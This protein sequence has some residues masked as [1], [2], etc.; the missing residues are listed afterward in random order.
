MLLSNSIAILKGVGE[1]TASLL[2]QRKIYT[3]GDL[4]YYLPRAYDDWQTNIKLKDVRAGN[5]VVKCKVRN[6][7]SERRKSLTIIKAELYDETNSIEAIWFNQSYRVKQLS[8]DKDF[9]FAGNFAFNYGRYQLSNP[10]VIVASDINNFSGDFLPVYKQCGDLK[11]KHFS[12]IINNLRSD[13]ATIPETLPTDILREVGIN[14]PLKDALYKIHFPETQQDVEIARQ[15][16]AFD[17]LLAWSLSAELNKRENLRLRAPSLTFNL[18]I[19]KKFVANLPFDLTDDQRL[20][21]F[22][23]AKDIEKSTPMSKMLQGDVGSGKTVVAMAV[24][25]LTF[26]NNFQSA[27]MVPTEVLARQHFDEFIKILQPFG[28]R[29]G[30]LVGGLTTKEKSDMQDQIKNGQIDIVI[31]THAL[32]SDKV[33]FARLGFAVIDEQHRFGVNQRTKL[34]VSAGD[35]LMPHLLSMTATPIPRT[36]Q[37]ALFGEMSV[38]NLRQKP[39]GRKDI[40]TK[41]TRPVSIDSVY[42]KIAEVIK[43]GQQVYYICPQ[44]DE[45]EDAENIDADMKKV[46]KEFQHLSHLFGKDNVA[47]LHGKMS[48]KEKDQIMTNFSN[49]K[50]QILVSTTVIEVGVNVPNA[51]LIIIRNADRFGLAALHQLRGR[52]GRSDLQS[53]CFLVTTTDDRPTQRL[54]EMEKSGD[55]FYLA[56]KDLKMRGAGEIYGALQH[57]ALSLRIATF[58]D[59]KIIAKSNKAAQKIIVR[60]ETGELDLRKFPDLEKA[61]LQNQKTTLLN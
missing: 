26:S 54:R 57:G 33:K 15:R 41:I 58:A 5:I 51:T 31:G 37:L 45:E 34:L 36:L 48:G 24:S 18:E 59:T 23:I 8:E 3:I 56:E 12:K 40:I 2:R 39:K 60:I 9:Y 11:S 19:M 30:L 50:T 38:F 61:V 43:N 6:V 47:F 35:N 49:Q 16:L 14:L 44:I 46:K 42:E 29:V 1:K 32:I 10:S 13:F 20:A 21:I 4:L 27:I 17:E 22:T 55:G 52:V 28:V 25:L 7:K 53:Y